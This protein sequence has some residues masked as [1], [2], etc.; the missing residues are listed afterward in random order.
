MIPIHLTRDE[1]RLCRDAAK[2]A[3]SE[4][5]DLPFLDHGEQ[6][7]SRAEWWEVKRYLMF[8]ATDPEI[9][10]E[11]ATRKA[12]ENLS[13]RIEA[14]IERYDATMPVAA[15]PEPVAAGKQGSLF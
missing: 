1:A 5:V 11:L 14:V 3:K 12:M 9:E 13:A 4:G 15:V 8:A 2:L 7:L 10:R 6:R